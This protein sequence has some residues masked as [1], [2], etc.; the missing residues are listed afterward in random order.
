MQ[1]QHELMV[2]TYKDNG[3]SYLTYPEKPKSAYGAIKRAIAAAGFVIRGGAIVPLKQPSTGEDGLDTSLS[4]L[5][6][7]VARSRTP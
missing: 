6:T 7:W 2:K 4:S 3:V 5:L 1:E